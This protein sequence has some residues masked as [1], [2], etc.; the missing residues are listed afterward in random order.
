MSVLDISKNLSSSSDG[1]K[2]RSLS[3]GGVSDSIEADL[4]GVCDDGL[5]DGLEGGPR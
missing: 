1:N 4:L 2:W 3:F 5:K